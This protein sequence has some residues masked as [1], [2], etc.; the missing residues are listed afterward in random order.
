MSQFLAHKQDYRRPTIAAAI[1]LVLIAIAVFGT[2]RAF[3]L[4]RPV[5]AVAELTLTEPLASANGVDAPT[6][7]Q[8]KAIERW[9]AA[10][11]SDNPPPE[12]TL[13]RA[14][15]PGKRPTPNVAL[16]TSLRQA[17]PAASPGESPA[18][19]SA[20][21]RSET[22]SNETNAVTDADTTP[23]VASD[24]LA[25]ELDALGLPSALTP[26]DDANRAWLTVRAEYAASQHAIAVV[27]TARAPQ[28]VLASSAAEQAAQRYA[29]YAAKRYWREAQAALSEAETECIAAQ[30]EL[31]SAKSRLADAA[32]RKESFELAAEMPTET[33][34]AGAM[35]PPASE[36]RPSN[37]PGAPHS[38]SEA[39]NHQ[40]DAEPQEGGEVQSLG[41]QIELLK[42]RRTFLLWQL[43]PKHPQIE[44]IDQEIAKLES[45]LAEL[46]PDSPLVWSAE[47]TSQTASPHA[48][49]ATATA[50]AATGSSAQ[51]GNADANP[52]AAGGDPP[53]EQSP[54]APAQRPP[55]A[56]ASRLLAEYN[57]A[58]AAVEQA[59]QRVEQAERRRQLC[60]F[61]LSNPLQSTLG[62]MRVSDPGQLFRTLALWPMAVL[63]GGL[64]I[65]FAAVT[66]AFLLYWAQRQRA[67][68]VVTSVEQLEQLV[69]LPVIPLVAAGSE[70]A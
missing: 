61:A 42:L 51:T 7:L 65:F 35:E 69:T 43:T 14:F 29:S 1:V 56:D 13:D 60:R 25:S 54:R 27:L 46:P 55:Q 11:A 28:V 59:E 37:P 38:V 18:D 9:V 10:Q 12:S 48:D 68:I 6:P 62:P 47:G 21:H 2:G 44:Q 20:T 15:P 57:E 50:D 64:A 67:A 70:H 19:E 41:R 40:P 66:Y 53:D 22:D 17:D 34:W 4:N 32:R 58:A 31:D 16:E 63:A 36:P 8:L 30:E 49:G 3:L 23:D 24:P 45:Q 52:A 33:P 5:V 39:V 26:G